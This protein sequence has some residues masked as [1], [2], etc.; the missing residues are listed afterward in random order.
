MKRIIFLAVIS[1]FTSGLYAQND[2]TFLKQK[3][4]TFYKHELKASSSDAIYAYIF[5]SPEVFLYANVSVAY[6][7]RPVKWFWVGGSFVNYFG[8]IIRYEWREYAPDGRFRDFSKSKLKY[9]GV[10]APEIRFSYLNRPSVILYSGLSGGVGLENG[11]DKKEKY[12]K[13]CAYFHITYVG[14]SINFGEKKNIFLGGEGGVGFK[15]FVNF[16][17]GYRF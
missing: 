14:F 16:H 13:P 12:P 2:S 3:S 1:L 17:G 5:W 8:G 9:Y 11:Y 6:L 4:N 7:Y 10:I 15:G